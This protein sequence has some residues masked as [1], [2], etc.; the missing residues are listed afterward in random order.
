M[1]IAFGDTRPTRATTVA[2][3]LATFI[4]L[5]ITAGL[6]ASGGPAP[7]LVILPIYAAFALWLSCRRRIVLDPTTR[8]IRITRTLFGRALTRRIPFA[9]FTAVDSRG[10]WVRPRGG[11]RLDDGT[12]EG[13]AHY[14]QP[15]LTLRR[16]RRRILLD[17]MTDAPRAE[18]LARDIAALV[19]VPAW[20]HDYTRR[21]DGLAVWLP[22][23]REPIG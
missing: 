23:A 5:V 7:L 15:D 19:G 2:L 10:R 12:P 16:G 9:A 14:I 8:D 18:A 20:R 22:G 4:L 3:A 21:A 1:P 17:R 13:D 6:L 11:G